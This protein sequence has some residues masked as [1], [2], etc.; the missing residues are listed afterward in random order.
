M[1]NNTQYDPQVLVLFCFKEQVSSDL[2][3]NPLSTFKQ[4]PFRDRASFVYLRQCTSHNLS[5]EVS[6]FY[7]YWM[8]EMNRVAI[9]FCFKAGLCATETLVLVQK[10]Y[11]NK[12]LNRSDVFRWYS[13]FR[14]GSELVYVQQ[15]LLQLES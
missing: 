7:M 1:C 2:L 9:K 5:C 6:F 13:R 8:A 3:A 14:Y 11:G 10:A 12:A 15:R 4:H